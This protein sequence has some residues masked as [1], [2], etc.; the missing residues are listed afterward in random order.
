MH[1]TPSIEMQDPVA[2][3]PGVRGADAVAQ[4]WLRQVTLRLRREVCWLW[5]ERARTVED[6]AQKIGAL[7]PLANRGV[8]ALDYARYDSERAVFF[9]E[10]VTARYLTDLINAAPVYSA[11]TR[12]GTFA[13]LAQRLQLEPVDCFVLALALLP[14]VDSAAGAVVATCLN[15]ATRSESTLALA[16]RLWDAPDELLHCFDPGHTLMRHGVLT[17][18]TGGA[19][20]WHASLSV[21]PL[22]ARELL[23]S[24]SNLPA[25]LERVVADLN[26]ASVAQAAED[27]SR[28]SERPPQR[29]R[30]VPLIGAADA[31]LDLAAAACA[32]RLGMRLVRPA[33]S[34]GR[35]QLRQVMTTAWLRGDALYLDKTWLDEPCSQPGHAHELVSDISSLAGLPLWLFIGCEDQALA[36]RFLRDAQ[37]SIKV[38]PLR[39]EQRLAAWRE[40]LPD[41]APQLLTEA[42]RRFRFERRAI[43]RVGAALAGLGRASSEAE[44]FAAAQTDLDVGA[45]AQIVTPRF[46]LGELMLNP[47]ATRQVDEIV[48]ATR[49]LARTHYDWGTARA[50]NESGL[51]A[52]FAGPPGTGKTMCAEAIGAALALPM[53]R[54]DLSQVMDKYIGQTEKNLRQLFDAADA[55]DAILFFDEADAL[56]GRRTAVKD[57][58]DRYAN[59]EISYLLERM[60]R[61]KGLAILA[62][63]R[64]KDLDEAFLRR[65]RFVVDFELPGPAERLRI[66]RSMIP[67]DVDA[68]ALDFDFLAQRFALSGGHIRAIVFHACLQCACDGAPRVLAMPA[69]VRAVQ[70]EYEKLERAHSLSQFGPYA[71]LI[72]APTQEARGRS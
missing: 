49:N 12:R 39:Y 17:F 21:P 3:M 28:Q 9:R 18:P 4:Y 11:S 71:S 30:V 68:S 35:D 47:A 48:T 25:A 36:R 14:C 66:W 34:L 72:D 55:A 13:A 24:R 7:P 1:N 60:E 53:Y 64:R 38:A 58:H 19:V 33:V 10:D 27:F 15:D 29:L 52:L 6:D 45:L 63:N 67:G 41:S 65:L 57:A 50:W 32:A 61:F 26:D 44:L 22:V 42:A 20:G 40:A 37:A 54:I 59:L 43:A 51:T 62:T 8:T 23:L 16:Q 56:F 69:I 2:F 31:P 70:R 46:T 5:R